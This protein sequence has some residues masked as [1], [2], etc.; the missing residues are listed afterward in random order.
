MTWLLVA[1]AGGLGA[2]TRFLLDGALTVALRPA[3][4]V[5]TVVV[6]V[7]G[8]F[9]LGLVAG[10]GGVSPELGLV[11][12]TGFLGGFTTF[13]T[14][15]VDVVRVLGARRPVAA[16]CLCAGMLASCVGAAWCGLLLAPGL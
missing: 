1:L 9:L 14:A 7:L 4:P 6:N 12:G 5:G 2:G 3:L 10:T 11:A 8:S 15:S 13:S 16:S